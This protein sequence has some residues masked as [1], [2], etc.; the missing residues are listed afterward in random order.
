MGNSLGLLFN[1]S[2]GRRIWDMVIA[3]L[4]IQ[5][6]PAWDL[7]SAV[8]PSPVMPA[9]W[10][11]CSAPVRTGCL[12]DRIGRRRNGRSPLPA[13]IARPPAPPRCL[14]A[15][16]ICW[17]KRRARSREGD[18]ALAGGRPDE[19]TRALRFCRIRCGRKDRMD[20]LLGICCWAAGI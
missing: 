16:R 19:A 12:D 13:R 14:G 15:A 4:G 5:E 9:C 2:R 8:A 20:G 17:G 18:A 10:P 11:L 1:L 3:V 6:W 7:S